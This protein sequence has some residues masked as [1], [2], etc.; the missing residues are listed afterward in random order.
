MDLI[1]T[2]GFILAQKISSEFKVSVHS[3]F[4]HPSFLEKF[5]LPRSALRL[6]FAF[7]FVGEYEILFLTLTLFCKELF[8]GALFHTALLCTSCNTAYRQSNPVH[9]YLDTKYDFVQNHY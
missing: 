8:Y 6:S 2:F 4:K 9:Q 1:H 7:A 5:N 3:W